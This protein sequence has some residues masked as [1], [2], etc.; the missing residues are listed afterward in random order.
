MKPRELRVYQALLDH[1][2]GLRKEEVSLLT[3]PGEVN[4]WWRQRAEM[5]LV[6]DGEGW[7]MEG[8]GERASLY[9]LCE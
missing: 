9:S 1:L 2:N 8:L 6:E 4:H 3:I 5:R 7:K